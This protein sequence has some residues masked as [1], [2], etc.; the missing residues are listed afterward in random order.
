MIGVAKSTILAPNPIVRE[1]AMIAPL[2]RLGAS[3]ARPRLR[4]VTTRVA[5]QT[6]EP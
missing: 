5:P 6:T 3:A 2:A 4:T 1:C